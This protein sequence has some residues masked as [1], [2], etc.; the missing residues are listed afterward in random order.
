MQ[1]GSE[2]GSTE[3]K[4]SAPASG[5]V[6]KPDGEQEQDGDGGEHDGEQGELNRLAGDG[7][8]H[9]QDLEHVDRSQR[10]LTGQVVLKRLLL[11]WSQWKAGADD[12]AARARLN[13]RAGDWLRRNRGLH[14]RD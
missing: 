14:L 7:R 9:L 11:R 5:H 6:A 2:G 8:P 1:E 3:L 13:H 12:E 10:G 4:S